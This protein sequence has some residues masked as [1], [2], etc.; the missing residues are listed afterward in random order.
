MKLLLDTNILL[1]IA[2]KRQPFVIQAAQVLTTAQHRKFPLY[3][4]ATTITDLFY[5]I[6]KAKGKA[7]ALAFITDLMQYVD[8]AA[9]DKAVVM[10]ALD[11][12]LPDFE[13]AIQVGSAE[14]AGIE[15]II[16]RNEP[17][18]EDSALQVL[19]PAQFLQ[20]YPMTQT[21]SGEHTDSG[22]DSTGGIR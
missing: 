7:V 1:D 18:F 10:R 2:L 5:I 22:V 16:T 19:N 14:R 6:R 3:M 4:T 12:E 20:Q 11:L 15:T 17:D 8:V 13:D 21:E 9:V